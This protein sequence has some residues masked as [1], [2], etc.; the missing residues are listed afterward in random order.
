MEHLGCH[1]VWALPRAPDLVAV[2]DHNV[3]HYL[4]SLVGDNPDGELANHLEPHNLT[5]NNQESIC[6]LVRTFLG[7]TV[8]APGSAKAP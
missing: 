5:L 8:F 6:N 2:L 4:R 7:M 3:L 1:L